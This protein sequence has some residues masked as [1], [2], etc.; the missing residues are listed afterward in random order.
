MD[1]NDQ[2]KQAGYTEKAN[3]EINRI[4]VYVLCFCIRKGCDDTITNWVVLN[5]TKR[6]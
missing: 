4:A 3:P 5:I 2:R 1:R 6:S